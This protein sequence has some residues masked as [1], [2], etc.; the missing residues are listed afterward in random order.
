LSPGQVIGIVVNIIGIE[1]NGRF[2]LE[3]FEQREGIVVIVDIPMIE[4]KQASVCLKMQTLMVYFENLRKCIGMYLIALQNL[5]TGFKTGRNR[6]KHKYRNALIAK[7]KK[8]N[9]YNEQYK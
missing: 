9:D 6:M 1:E 4:S 3:S 7:H 8:E 5:Q 2:K